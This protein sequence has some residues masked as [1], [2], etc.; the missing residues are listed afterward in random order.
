MLDTP[1]EGR[2]LD[3]EKVVRSNKE[4]VAPVATSKLQV[5]QSL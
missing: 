1:D 4:A 2:L 3:K 5:A